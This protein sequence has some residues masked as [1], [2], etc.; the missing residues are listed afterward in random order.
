MRNCRRKKKKFSGKIKFAAEN[1]KLP[2]KIQIAGWRAN[3]SAEN[4]N[5]RAKI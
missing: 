1:L 4:L 3:V 5:F 2:L